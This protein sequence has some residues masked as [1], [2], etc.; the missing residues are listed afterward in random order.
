MKKLRDRNKLLAAP[1]TVSELGFP[2]PAPH[3]TLHPSDT[4][5]L[6]NWKHHPGSLQTNL[7]DS[8]LPISTDR[9]N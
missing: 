3:Q 7:K 5:G 8:V 1:R 4:S 2:F 9:S 6:S